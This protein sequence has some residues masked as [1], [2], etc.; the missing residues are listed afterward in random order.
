MKKIRLS[1][2]SIAATFLLSSCYYDNFKELHPSN[3]LPAS[4]TSS[5]DTMAAI[6]YSTQIVP[7]LTSAC[8]QN[9][10][11]PNTGSHDM[12]NYTAVHSDAVSGALYADVNSGSMPI[13]GSKIS[14]CDIAK[15]KL[16]AAS[17]SPN[18]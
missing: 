15:I 6:S 11:N 14:A 7:I 16:W 8:T 17:G 13:S 1:F 3:A 18:N 5:C 10:H 9:C 4:S 12:T 2:L